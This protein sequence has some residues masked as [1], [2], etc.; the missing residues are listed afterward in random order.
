MSIGHIIYNKRMLEM[1]NQSGIYKGISW[2]VVYKG[3]K[4]FELTVG[5]KTEIYSCLYTPI[6]GLDILD[7]QGINLQLDKM[8][9][10][11]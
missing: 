4:E 7:Q 8:Q 6:F 9:G 5:D 10:L 2:S 11:I 3:E 1:F